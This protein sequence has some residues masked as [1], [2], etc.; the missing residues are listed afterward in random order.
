MLPTEDSAGPRGA[1]GRMKEIK[2]LTTLRALAALLVF[3]YH[4]AYLH[5]S[6]QGALI[7]PAWLT[8]MPVWRSGQIGVSIFFVLSGF[9]ITRIYYDDFADGKGGL[10]HFYVK[11]IARIWP[12]FLL[13]AAI[14]HGVWLAQG[15]HVSASWLVTCSMTQGF[16]SDLRYGGLPTAWSLTIEESFYALAPL[17]YVLIA[18]MALGRAGP[19]PW[20]ATRVARFATVMVMLAAAG[21]GAGVAI[22]VVCQRLGWT[23]AGFMGDSNHVLRSTLSGRFP[24]FA[25]G[26]VCAFVH[27]AGVLHRLGT[28]QATALAITCVVAIGAC[29]AW[30]DYAGRHGWLGSSYVSTGVIVLLS[31][32]LILALTRE[33]SWV[34]RILSARLPV[35]LG[36][37]SYGFYLIQIS[38]LMIPF[39]AIANRFGP[40]RLPVL[41][42]L[43]NLVCAAC[44]ELYE[45]PAR[46]FITARLGGLGPRREAA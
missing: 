25:V 7:G 17:M 29:A 10:R 3:M 34:S 16:F 39:V 24:E 33:D 12:L 18:A 45:R 4:Y 9:L 30:K 6:A 37:V 46:R 41:F 15:Q 35:Y 43:M 19:R 22:M 23:F 1:A 31:G 28:K 11:R 26:I 44:F 42:V 32:I 5:A 27:R 40:L 13:F 2:A 36:K 14:Q 21:L 38:A 20:T 8:L